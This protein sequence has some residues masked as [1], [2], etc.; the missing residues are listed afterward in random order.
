VTTDEH[1]D[2]GTDR[3]V[4]RVTAEANLAWLRTRLALENTPM[5]WVRTGISLIGFGFNIVEIFNRLAAQHV[6]RT[7][8]VA[9]NAPVC[10]SRPDRGGRGCPGNFVLPVRLDQQLLRSPA[11][12]ANCRSARAQRT[13]AEPR[14]RNRAKETLKNGR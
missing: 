2:A 6:H 8:L 12:P 4:L 14:H 5:P 13:D 7:S 1:D 3:F 11:V 9:G 10:G